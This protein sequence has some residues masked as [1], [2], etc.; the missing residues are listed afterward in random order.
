[1]Q[2]AL[3]LLAA[4]PAARA[5]RL[6]GADRAGAGPAA[7]GGVAALVQPVV[8]DV[9]GP[10]VVPDLF[11]GPAHERVDLHQAETG[12]GLDGRGLGAVGGL[13]APDGGDPGLVA[14]E[15]LAQRL[16]LA[17]LAAAVGLALPEPFALGGGLLGHGAPG[18]HAA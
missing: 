15:G 2:A 10:H 9:L 7:D 8:G 6:P 13:V 12:I 17:Q 14:A 1:M 5:R 11:A 3:R 4:A 18:L 16:D